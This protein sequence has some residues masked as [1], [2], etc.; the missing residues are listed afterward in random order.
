MSTGDMNAKPEF[1]RRAFLRLGG[2]GALALSMPLPRIY[3]GDPAR[4]KTNPLVLIYLR[5][6]QDA[7]N[8]VVPYGDPRYYD[9]RPTIAI[10]KKDGPDGKGVIAVKDNADEGDPICIFPVD[11]GSPNCLLGAGTR[12]NRDP[13]LT[14]QGS[15]W[16]LFY[17][18]QQA[19]GSNENTW[20]Q[21]Y[22]YDIPR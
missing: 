1:N 3:F 10:P 12:N 21:M 22:T 11:G 19:S 6:G 18:A 8:T 15:T 2:S 20:Q 16:R 9:I 5:G 4:G 14:M 13:Q 7:L 17:T